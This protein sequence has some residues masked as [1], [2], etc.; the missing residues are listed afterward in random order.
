MSRALAALL[1]LALSGTALAQP[2]N[3]TV[4][5]RGTIEKLE[6]NAMTVKARNGKAMMVRLADHYGVTGVRKASVSDIAAG[7]YVGSTTVGE[8]GGSLVADEVHIFMDS[9]RGLAEGHFDW[10]SRPHS[11]MTNANVAGVV[12]MQ[13]DRVITVQYKGGEKKILVTPRTTVVAFAPADKSELKPGAPVFVVAQR[14]PD[15]ALTAPRVTVGLGGQVPP[16]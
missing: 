10:D 14:Q 13:G 6:G 3:P 8:K 15:G 1:L 16:M 11:K 9:Q 2:A 12:S 5:V 7:K 4:R